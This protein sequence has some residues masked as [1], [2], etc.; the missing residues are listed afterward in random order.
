MET[1]VSGADIA[2]DSVSAYAV[3][4][5]ARLH[6]CQDG[7]RRLLSASMLPQQKDIRRAIIGQRE[8]GAT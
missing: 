7:C 1:D 8:S 3:A 4:S 6:T 2:T 5:S